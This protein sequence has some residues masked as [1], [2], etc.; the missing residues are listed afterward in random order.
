MAIQESISYDFKISKKLK[1]GLQQLIDKRK[2]LILF[3]KDKF[4]S[5]E[6]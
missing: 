4:D 6:V 3:W 5:P 2:I 1:Q